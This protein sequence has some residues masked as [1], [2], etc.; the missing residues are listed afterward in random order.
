MSNHN[1]TTFALKAQPKARGLSDRG[2]DGFTLKIPALIPADRKFAKPVSPLNNI[3][4]EQLDKVR[5]PR[6][7]CETISSTPKTIEGP[8][9]DNKSSSPTAQLRQ[10]Y[11]DQLHVAVCSIFSKIQAKDE[12]EKRAYHANRKPD[13]NFSNR[14]TG[15]MQFTAGP[16]PFVDDKLIYLDVDLFSNA[17]EAQVW[18]STYE[19]YHKRRNELALVGSAYVG[20]DPEK[21]YV[22]MMELNIECAEF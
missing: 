21:R 14:P 6:K 2:E 18:N 22:E 17:W 3:P 8:H 20:F 5:N 13:H 7:P 4:P 15:F 10:K 1:S 12:E 19:E 11:V 9:D 16:T